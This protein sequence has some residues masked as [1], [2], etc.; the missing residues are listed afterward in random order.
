MAGDPFG[1]RTSLQRGPR[2]RERCKSLLASIYP[3]SIFG[4]DRDSSNRAIC[5]A[6]KHRTVIEI[7]SDDDDDDD[8]ESTPGAKTKGR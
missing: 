2:R 1:R 7:S 4:V 5:R 3:S 6:Q 8:G